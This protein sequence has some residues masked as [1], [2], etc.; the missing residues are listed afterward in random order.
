MPP[1]VLTYKYMVTCDNIIQKRESGNNSY[2]VRTMLIFYIYYTHVCPHTC[3]HTN[4]WSP[5]TILYKKGNLGITRILYVLCSY[6]TFITLMCA[7]TRTYIQ[8]YGHLIK[9]VLYEFLLIKKINETFTNIYRCRN[10]KRF[11]Q[12]W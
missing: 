12:R 9:N 4:I 8:I 3:L 1:H 7:P 6:S 10:W 11:L 5:V 2:I